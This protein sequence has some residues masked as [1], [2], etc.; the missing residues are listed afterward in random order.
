MVAE[1]LLNALHSLG[2]RLRV[3]TEDRT[4]R[5]AC[6]ASTLRRLARRV[7]RL[8]ALALGQLQ[9]RSYAPGQP[10]VALAHEPGE[11]GLRRS[12][13]DVNDTRTHEVE[14]IIQQ[15][16]V[17]PGGELVQHVVVTPQPFAGQP[18]G[19]PALHRTEHQRLALL[20]E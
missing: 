9:G 12:D 4:H 11:R 16:R 1:D 8:L 14:E 17:R 7:Q 15:L 20:P 6:V 5:L 18:L 3:A 19:D 2:E 13:T 10:S